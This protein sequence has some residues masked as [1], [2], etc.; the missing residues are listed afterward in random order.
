M[1]YKII[2]SEHNIR[3]LGVCKTIF[4]GH[5]STKHNRHEFF[6]KY[7]NRYHLESEH[8]SHRIELYSQ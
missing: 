6:I 4:K 3:D 2:D 8:T 1:K 5:R 7:K